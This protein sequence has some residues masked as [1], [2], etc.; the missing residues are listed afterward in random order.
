MNEASNVEPQLC[1]Y[2][3][4]LERLGV[5]VT[6][7]GRLTFLRQTLPSVLAE[8]PGVYC[9]VDYGCPEQSGAWVE[10]EYTDEVERG[11]IIVHRVPNVNVFHKTDA[12][13]QGARRA[14]R[15]GCQYL[16]FL[17]ADTVVLNRFW[18]W[19]AHDWDRSKFLVA[20]LQSMRSLFGVLVVG[21]QDFERVGGYDEEFRGWGNEDLELRLRLHLLGGLEYAHLPVHVLSGISHGDWLRTRHYSEKSR[22]A[23][24]AKNW[25]Y[26]L[27]KVRAWTGRELDQLG[28]TVAPLMQPLCEEYI[29]PSVD[30]GNAR[31]M[32]RRRWN[33]WSVRR[34]R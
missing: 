15:A 27:C 28:P 14:M 6:C 2:P 10:S 12:L 3:L 20:N 18:S 4:D 17:D 7:M 32:G 1:P 13:N 24:F 9:L 34:R 29:R 30:E 23:S 25:E 31:T 26:M 33:R 22:E 5:I 8:F 11:R 16:C 19:L 21:A